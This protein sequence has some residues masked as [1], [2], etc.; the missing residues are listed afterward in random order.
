ME[1]PPEQITQ[2]YFTCLTLCRFFVVGTVNSLLFGNFG[3]AISE[4]LQCG[5]MNVVVMISEWTL[6]VSNRMLT[7]PSAE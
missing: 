1:I 3:L 2:Y 7:L 6:M 5:Q 4:K